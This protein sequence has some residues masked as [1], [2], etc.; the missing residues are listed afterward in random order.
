M[1]S[2]QQACTLDMMK[3]AIHEEAKFRKDDYLR[4][5]TTI[6]MI[7]DAMRDIWKKSPWKFQERTIQKLVEMRN[8]SINCSTLLLVQ[9]TGGG[10]SVVIQTA[11]CLN[12]GIMLVIQSTLSLRV[13]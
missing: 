2:F 8:K 3:N 10:K 9:G 1:V 4:N 11:A 5:R 12:L 7:T 13:N 6:E